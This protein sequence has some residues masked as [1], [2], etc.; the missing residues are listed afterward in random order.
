MHFQLL[1]KYLGQI[2]TYNKCSPRWLFWPDRNVLSPYRGGIWAPSSYKPFWSHRRRRLSQCQVPANSVSAHNEGCSLARWKH[3]IWELISE[4]A[5]TLHYIVIVKH[6]Y[7]TRFQ[8]MSFFAT[9]PPYKSPSPYSGPSPSVYAQ[10]PR[11]DSHILWNKKL[12]S[13][14]DPRTHIGHKDCTWSSWQFIHFWQRLSFLFWN[15]HHSWMIHGI[16]AWSHLLY[17]RSQWISDF[18]QVGS[19]VVRFPDPLV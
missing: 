12:R 15:W 2:Y 17:P 3:I 18:H 11:S 19:S 14:F 4:V 1:M 9:S 10:P 16:F 13:I 6:V 7:W 8:N 5:C